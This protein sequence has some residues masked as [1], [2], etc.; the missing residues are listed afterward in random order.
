[1][2][3]GGQSTIHKNL[4]DTVKYT[5]SQAWISATTLKIEVFWFDDDRRIQRFPFVVRLE[6]G[7]HI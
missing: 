7:P 2:W 4:G 1:M 3:P 5:S 6:D